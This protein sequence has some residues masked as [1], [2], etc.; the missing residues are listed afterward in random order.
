MR[1]TEYVYSGHDGEFAEFTNIGNA[2][3]DLNGWSFDDDRGVSGTIALGAIGI[4]KAGESVLLTDASE[5]DFR[6]ACNLCS[7]IR[8]VG[9]E[10]AGLGRVDEI[11]LSDGNFIP[12][13]GLAFNNQAAGGGPRTQYAG[14]WV[15]S[16]G[17]GMHTAS[18]WTQST[19]GDSEDLVASTQTGVATPERSTQATISFD[20]CAGSTG[21]P[22]VSVDRTATSLYLDL[23]E[24][25]SGALS[26]VIDDPTDPAASTGIGF[27]F[28]LPGG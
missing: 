20:P 14:A 19:L 13:D 6:T 9:H 16:A 27:T 25:G 8:I 23:A 2:P 26:G 15:S 12:I 5:A 10:S 28:A 21:A 22:I 3:L 17:L 4:V 24:I 11:N 1:I 18:D 7:A